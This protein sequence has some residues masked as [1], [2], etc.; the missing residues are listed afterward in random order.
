MHPTTDHSRHL[1]SALIAAMLV[2]APSTIGLAQNEQPEPAAAAS[3]ATP[4]D[5]PLSRRERRRA[6]KAQPAAQA[7]PAAT[8]G[9]AA[10]AAEPAVETEEPEIVCKTIKPLG[11]KVG[12]RVCGTPEQWAASTRRS[13]DGARDAMREISSRSGFPAAPEA[14][15]AIP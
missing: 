8:Q 9:Q 2:A 10:A 4:A 11:S 1:A 7:P 13:S 12:R 3:R 6:A 15:A 14:P 5:E